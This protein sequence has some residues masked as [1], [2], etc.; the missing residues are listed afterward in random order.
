MVQWHLCFNPKK[1]VLVRFSPRPHSSITHDYLINDLSIS[2]Q[3]LYH[4]FGVI[5]TSN[6]SWNEHYKHLLSNAYRILSLIRRTFITTHCPQNKRTLCLLLVH[7][8]LMYCSPVWRPQFI[9]DIKVIERVQ[10]QAT[11]FILDDYRSDYKSRLT[12]LNMLPFNDAI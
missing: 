9:K 6:L 5:L 7:S 3:H 11:K 2:N 10:R 8:R 1:C 12:S 4:D